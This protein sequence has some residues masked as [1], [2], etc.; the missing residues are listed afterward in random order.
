MIFDEL[1]FDKKKKSLTLEEFKPILI[2]SNLEKTCSID[3]SYED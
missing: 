3:F 1:I 2:G